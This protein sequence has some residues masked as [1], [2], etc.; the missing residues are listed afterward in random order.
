MYP[1]KFGDIN[2]LNVD[3]IYTNHMIVFT[4]SVTKNNKN[5]FW[6]YLEKAY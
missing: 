4:L 1:K 2:S 3:A 5:L 6:Q